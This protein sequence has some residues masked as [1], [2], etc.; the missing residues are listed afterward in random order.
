MKRLMKSNSIIL[1]L[2][3]L[4]LSCSKNS[5][6]SEDSDILTLLDC[7]I[8]TTFVLT[9]PA[10][11]IARYS[12]C[13]YIVAGIYG[14]EIIDEVGNLLP[15]WEDNVMRVPVVPSTRGFSPTSDGGYLTTYIDFVSKSSPPDDPCNC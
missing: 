10:V 13:R 12:D 14:A 2:A 6:S 5:S 15:S 1:I 3:V 8:D 9:L 7:G 11:D 4:I